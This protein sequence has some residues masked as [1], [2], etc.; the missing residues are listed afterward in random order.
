MFYIDHLLW[1]SLD[2]EQNTINLLDI[3]YVLGL[4]TL[5]ITIYYHDRKIL[6]QYDCLMNKLYTSIV[7]LWSAI[8]FYKAEKRTVWS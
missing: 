7:Q 8:R 5:Y 1:A 2:M 6:S 4:S 3:T